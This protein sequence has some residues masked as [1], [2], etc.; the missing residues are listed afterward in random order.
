MKVLKMLHVATVL[1]VAGVAAANGGDGKVMATTDSLELTTSSPVVT[2]WTPCPTGISMCTYNP[3][4]ATQAAQASDLH[5]P[6]QAIERDGGSMTSPVVTFWT[7]CPTGTSMCTYNPSMVT[8]PTDSGA[9]HATAH[10]GIAQREAET[11]T[12]LVVTFWTPCPTGTSMCTY[13]PTTTDDSHNP[14]GRVVERAAEETTTSPVVT[15]WTPCPTGTSMCTYN[16]STVTGKPTD[17]AFPRAAASLGSDSDSTSLYSNSNMGQLSKTVY[18]TLATITADAGS[19]GLTTYTGEVSV[20]SMAAVAPPSQSVGMTVAS[21]GPMTTVVTGMAVS[22][23]YGA[24]PITASS[25]LTTQMAPS[26][27]ANSTGLPDL[28]NGT[29]VRTSTGTAV[30]ATS[31]TA[32]SEVATPSATASTAGVAP[33]TA[34]QAMGALVGLAGALAFV[35]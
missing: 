27:A 6:V 19:A 3:T 4:T 12:T 28:K 14:T 9:V 21:Q 5:A 24:A 13:N 7:P 32:T 16:P 22:M 34:K 17:A 33:T 15:F 26:G 29:T 20:V 11:T 23:P 1:A 25:S 35:L 31:S 2:F 18:T 8:T 30:P 10:A